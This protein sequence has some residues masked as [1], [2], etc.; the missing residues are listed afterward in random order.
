MRLRPAMP[1]S[2]FA[3]ALLIVAGWSLIALAQSLQGYLVAAYKGQPQFWWPMLGYVAA[4]YSI[5]AM[6]TWPIVAAVRAIERRISR[7]WARLAAYLAIW[8]I[9][10]GLH[11]LLFSL[12]YWPVYRGASAGTRW[13][14]ADIMFV[15]NYGT[16]TLLYAALIGVTIAWLRWPSRA[17]PGPQQPPEAGALLIRNRGTVHR[18]P[19]DA[20]DWIGA[21]GDYAEVHEQGRVHL[22]EESLASLAGRLPDGAFARIH[23]GAL[24]RIDRIREIA[25]IGRGDAYVRLVTGEE[26]RLSRRF[27]GNLAGLI[28]P[29]RPA[30]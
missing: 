23:R 22:I 19:Y 2:R 16:N 14:M 5:W 9:A 11:V 27:R 20:I 6:L 24:I 7:W 15:R 17:A 21:A 3:L 1:D 29:A 30:E 10:A 25:P 12:I 28:G 8:P 26:L 13:E 18:I 4:I